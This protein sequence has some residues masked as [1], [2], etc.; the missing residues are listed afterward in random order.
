VARAPPSPSANPVPRSRDPY[1]ESQVQVWRGT[2]LGT[3]E[4]GGRVSSPAVAGVRRSAFFESYSAS[5]CVLYCA[6]LGAAPHLAGGPA[7]WAGS[8]GAMFEGSDTGPLSLA[9]LDS[10][11]TPVGER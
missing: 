10:S 11:P 6:A 8:E 3:A 5:K 9:P 1:D 2:W 4:P 7:Q